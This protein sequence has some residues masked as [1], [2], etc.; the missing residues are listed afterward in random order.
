[1]EEK[2]ADDSIRRIGDS[3][4]TMENSVLRAKESAARRMLFSPRENH[5]PDAVQFEKVKKKKEAHNQK[6]TISP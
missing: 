3:N 5:K 1:M 2:R 4:H 6:V